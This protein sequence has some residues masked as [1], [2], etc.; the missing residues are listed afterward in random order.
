MASG[1]PFTPRVEGDVNGDGHSN[2]AAYIFDPAAMPDPLVARGMAE[3]LRSAPAGAAECLHRQLGTLAR[4]NSCRGP[5]TGEMNVQAAFWPGQDHRSRRFTVTATLSNVL[6]GADRLLHG[7]RGARGWGQTADPDPTLLYVR[8]FD[9]DALAFRYGVNPA[10]GSGASTTRAATRQPFALVVQGRWTFGAD[11]VR[12]P[13]TTVLSTMRVQGRTRAQLRAALSSTVPNLPAQVL[14]LGDS[15]RVDLSLRDREVLRAA[16]DA[17]GRRVAP[18]VDSLA[19]ALS[20]A[21]ST[22]DRGREKAAREEVERLSGRAQAALDAAVAGLRALLSPT[23][24][25]RLPAAV[26]RPS[27][28]ILPSRGGFTISTGEPW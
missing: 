5:W 21:E 14:A 18:L 24:W 2:D 8:G 20:T 9:P 12:Q 25:E 10:F 11:P 3:L 17:F 27:R 23:Q 26:Q 6:A 13:L 7:T 28:Q 1:A 22:P 16:A 19:Q 15:A 4:R